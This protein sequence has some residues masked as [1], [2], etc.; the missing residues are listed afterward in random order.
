MNRLNPAKE[1][2]APEFIPANTDR[3]GMRKRFDAIGKAIEKCMGK[4]FFFVD[5]VLGTDNQI[6]GVYAGDGE[7]VQQESWKLAD[8][9]TNVYLNIKDKF[10]VL[11]FGEPRVFHY[12][13]GHGT[14]PTLMFQA[15]GAQLTRNYDVFNENGVIICASLCDGW[16]NDEWFP[17]Y[18]EVYKKL[19]LVSDSTEIVRFEVEVSN[20]PEYIYNLKSR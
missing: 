16:F 11:V 6:L 4:K 2:H 8:Q 14:N 10:D 3:S 18:R 13:P 7:E 15:I 5:V 20:R 17:S 1:K 9:R 19:Q 12:G